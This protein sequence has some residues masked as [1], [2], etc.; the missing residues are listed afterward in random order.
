L[1]EPEASADPD[2][3]NFY[4]DG[5][6]VPYDEDC[7]AGVG[8]MWSNEDHTEVTFCEQACAEL[9]GGGVDLVTA[10]FGCPSVP[11]E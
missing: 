5:E 2:N 8:W 9:Q 4:F 7:G 3:V 11:V 10:K 1:D 6:V